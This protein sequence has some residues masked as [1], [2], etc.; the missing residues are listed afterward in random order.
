[1]RTVISLLHNRIRKKEEA[2]RLKNLP[3]SFVETFYKYWLDDIDF[4]QDTDFQQEILKNL[5]SQDVKK[6]LL[7][8][9]KFGQDIQEKIDLCVT[10]DRLNEASFRRKLNH[11]SKNIIKSKNRIKLLFSDIKHFDTQNPVIG[12]LICKIDI[13]KKKGSE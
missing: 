8:T 9:S 2:K 3:G 11:I 4:S 13:G 5:Q 6:Y 12:Y 7:A 1:M 10:N